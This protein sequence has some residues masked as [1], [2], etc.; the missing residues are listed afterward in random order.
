MKELL[1]IEEGYYSIGT[2]EAWVPPS[3]P[4]YRLQRPKDLVDE[5]FLAKATKLLTTRQQ[6]EERYADWKNHWE[7]TIRSWTDE[8]SHIT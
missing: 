6:D 8:F 1:K 3:E 2:P 7:H 4:D 5:L